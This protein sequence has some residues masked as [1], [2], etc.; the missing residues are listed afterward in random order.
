M[1]DLFRLG[2]TTPLELHHVPPLSRHDAIDHVMSHFDPVWTAERQKHAPRLLRAILRALWPKL[3]HAT[4][5]HTIYLTLNLLMPSMVQGIVQY[6]EDKSIN[7]VNGLPYKN[8]YAGYFFA[9]ILSVLTFVSVTI[10]GYAWS[11]N[12]ELSTNARSIVMDLVYTK[13]MQLSLTGTPFTPGDI[14][15][16]ATVDSERVFHGLTCVCY[17]VLSPIALFAVFVL[18]RY[19]FCIYSAAAGA[20]TMT[21][22]IVSATI[23]SKWIAS[24]RSKLLDATAARMTHTQ[25][26]LHGIRVVKLYA[27]EPHLAQSLAALR[28]TELRL[29][30]LFQLVCNINIDLFILAPIFTT[31]AVFAVAMRSGN[32]GCITADKTA[33]VVSLMVVARFPCNIFSSAVRYFAEAVVSCRRVQAFL[34]SPDCISRDDRSHPYFD[35]NDAT[36][37]GSTPSL[38]LPQQPAHLVFQVRDGYFTWTPQVFAHGD[39]APPPPPPVLSPRGHAALQPLQALLSPPSSSNF[40]ADECAASYSISCHLRHINLMLEPQTMTIVV[41]AVGSGKSSLLRAFLGDMPACGN[42]DGGLGRMRHVSGIVA[43]AAQE[44]WLVHDT[45]RNNILLTQPLCAASYNRAVHA[46]GLYP[47]F[48]NM[49][50]GDLTEIGE[51]GATLSGGQRARINLARTLYR[52]N[53]ADL[54]LLDDPL[55][56]LDVTVA[57]EVFGRVRAVLR[58]KTTLMVL[59]GHHHLL[60]HADRIVVM[61]HGTIV[62]DGT[63]AE[64]QHQHNF[65]SSV[66]KNE[67]AQHNESQDDDDSD[68]DDSDN[69]AARVSMLMHTEQRATGAVVLRVFW[70][71]FG[72]SGYP[73]SVV[74][75]TLLGA[76]TAYQVVY[77]LADWILNTKIS[78]DGGASDGGNPPPPSPESAHA[79]LMLYLGLACLTVV[80]SLVKDMYVIVISTLCATKL[81]ANAIDGVLGASITGF[82]DRTPSGGILNRFSSDVAAV[83]IDLPYFGYQF[84]TD[85]FQTLC[86]VV[87]LAYF[88]PLLMVLYIPVGYLFVWYQMYNLTTANELKRL[89]LGSRSTIVSQL[90]DVVDGQSTLRVYNPA[91]VHTAFARRY[92][93]ACDT[94]TKCYL[95]YWLTGTWLE[96]RLG[97]LSACMLTAVSFLCVALESSLD[98]KNASLVLVYVMS[99]SANIQEVLR[100]VGYVQTYMTSVERLMQYRDIPHEETNATAHRLRA[101]SSSLPPLSE[102]ELAQWPRTGLVRF[103]SYSMRYRSS[104]PLALSRVSLTVACG[105]HIGICGRTG[106]GKSSLVAALCR[107]VEGEAG[108]IYWDNINIASI[109]LHVL[110][111]KL[112]IIPQ[113]PVMFSGSLRFNL[114]PTR[115]HT[116]AELNAVLETVHLGHM[117]LED[118]IEDSGANLSVGQRQLVC[119]GRALLRHSKVVVLD[120]ATAH[121]DGAAEAL[122]QETLRVAFKHTTTLTIAHRLDTIMDSD[123]ILVLDRGVVVEFDA[124]ATLLADPTSSFYDL[125][126]Q[127]SAQS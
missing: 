17:V 54:F 57:N 10:L 58:D 49:A 113:S 97:W 103:Q 41:G 111:S 99:L 124:P 1:N 82:F 96:I 3:L 71:Y 34:V 12:I 100:A 56:A 62:A 21:L 105:E 74:C 52:H 15:T 27:W 121:V 116:D 104:H 78:M 46:C 8:P 60:Q 95:T 23:V 9:G 86:I 120:E 122:L 30:R 119:I 72:S 14:L 73:P 123:R 109:P 101:P 102:A 37:T 6:L 77:Y 25:E 80:L 126:Q 47:D 22:F 92:R 70:S 40:L 59:N 19:H 106:S 68:E 94:N 33:A 85:A 75:A 50:Q 88:T 42:V 45:V 18:V 2:K 64:L 118:Y 83:D 90:T 16:F 24:C 87:V 11:V 81:H 28:R 39:A 115:T 36:T 69:V 63:F 5:C 4:M 65:P 31:V 107:L 117:A 48:A 127:S 110:R 112:T 98:A 29:L 20:A 76:Y 35:S 67:P 91:V 43:Y 51:R 53:D 93:D 38:D 79:H 13:A 84:L 55:S 61:A 125:V 7:P 26:I 32:D 114:D 108:G 44:P 89:D 66:E